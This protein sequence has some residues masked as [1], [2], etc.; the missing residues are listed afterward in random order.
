MVRV[1][2]FEMGGARIAN[3]SPFPVTIALDDKMKNRIEFPP[4]EDYLQVDLESVVIGYISVIPVV[5]VCYENVIGL[6]DPGEIDY[7]ILPLPFAY[8]LSRAIEWEDWK[9][10]VLVPN[11]DDA[12]KKQGKIVGVRSLV[13]F[14]R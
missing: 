10:R 11:P 9:G 6:P 12:I 14:E 2:Y 3:L 4:C 5:K 13:L 1:S 7:I 8:I